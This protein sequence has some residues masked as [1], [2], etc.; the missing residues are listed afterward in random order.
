[1]QG[2]KLERTLVERTARDG[3]PARSEK[4][5]GAGAQQKG[6]GSRQARTREGEPAR[7]NKGRGARAQ[8]YRGIEVD[9]NV[10]Y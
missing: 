8:Q 6:K 4:G 9:L 10:R 2:R 1:L 7:N 3:A 5:T